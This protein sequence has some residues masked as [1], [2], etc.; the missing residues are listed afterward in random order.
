M[1][2]KSLAENSQELAALAAE[3]GASNDNTPATTNA[4]RLPELK[5]NSQI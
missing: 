2:K 3:M 1:V 4:M 5:I